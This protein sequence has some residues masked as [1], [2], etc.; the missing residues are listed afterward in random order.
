M[1]GRTLVV[2][3]VAATTAA[4]QFSA[5]RLDRL[6]DSLAASGTRALLIVQRGQTVYEWYA[7]GNRADTKQGTAS[8]AKAIVGGVSLMLAAEDGRIGID[9]PAWKYIPAWKDDPLKSKITIRHLAT[10]SSGIEDAE[11]NRKPHNQLTG[12]KGD[13][14]KRTPDP[15]TIAIHQAP[16]VLNRCLG[17]RAECWS[18]GAVWGSGELRRRVEASASRRVCGCAA[19]GDAR[20]AAP[21]VSSMGSLSSPRNIN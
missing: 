9:D 5:E 1:I 7:P 12:W 2:T 4:G 14:R 11:E 6:R 17:A 13:F 15:F 10:H 21:G 16:V 20:G 19:P 3:A 18:R 8:L